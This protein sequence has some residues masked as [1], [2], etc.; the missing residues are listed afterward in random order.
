MALPTGEEMRARGERI[1]RRI[2]EARSTCGPNSWPNVE[3]LLEEML[4][5]QGEA[6]GWIV[7]RAGALGARELL[8]EMQ[9]DELVASLLRL[10]GLHPEAVERRIGRALERVRPR[11][12]THLGALELVE[13][14]REGRA[15]ISV[16]PREAARID[17]QELERSIREAVLEEAPELAEVRVV[18]E[19]LRRASM[20]VAALG[21]PR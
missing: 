4:Q 10:H 1:A 7:E 15:V 18:D 21:A 9:D 20:G 13:V 17:P 5:L 11:Y 16:L 19:R 2:E 14:D 8:R 12:G 6:L 3:R